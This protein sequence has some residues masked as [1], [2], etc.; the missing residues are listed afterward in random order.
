MSA[1]PQQV[2]ARLEALQ[3]VLGG[4]HLGADVHARLLLHL[5]QPGQAFHAHAF[6]AARLGAGFPDACTEYLL[7]FRGQLAGGVHHLFFGFGAAWAGD[8]Y[9]AFFGDAGELDSF[10]FEFHNYRVLIVVL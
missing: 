2:D 4:G 8:D 7:P 5:L 9:R 1:N 6:E 3:H 10:K